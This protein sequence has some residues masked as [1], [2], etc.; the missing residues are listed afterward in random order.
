M[1]RSLILRA[2]LISL[3]IAGPLLAQEFRATING[4]ISDTSDAAVPGATVLVK[5]VET[6]QVTSTTTD[7]RGNYTASFLRPGEYTVTVEAAGF[8]KVTRS[9]LVLNVGQTA[10][11][12]IALQVSAVV[13]EV[14]VTGAT[15]LLEVS[16]ADRGGVIDPQRVAELPLLFRNP[17]FL[18]QVVPGVTYTGTPIWQRP[19]DNGAMADWGVS[20]SRRRWGEFLLDGSPN[21]AQAGGNNI[22]YVPPVD[23]VQ[24]FKIHLNSYDAQYGKT[25][26]PIMNVTLKSGGN[27]FHGTIYEFLRRTGLDANTFQ[28]NAQ[29]RPR[30]PNLQDQYGFQAQGPVYFPKL[31]NGKDKLFFMTNYERYRDQA[32]FPLTVSVPAPEF[33]NGDF[34]KLVDAQGRQI[35]IYDPATGRQ[36]GSQWVRDPFKGNLIPQNRI[37]SVAAKILSYSPAPNLTTKGVGYT[38]SNYTPPG[39]DTKDDFYNLVFKFDLN[40]GDKHRVFFHDVS[41]QRTEDS[42]ETG[43]IKE[44]PGA[45]GN[46]NAM[47]INDN[48]TGD[49]VATLQPTLIFN[50]RLSFSRYCYYGEHRDN[51]SFDLAQLGLPASTISQ[52]YFPKFFGYYQFSGYSQMGKQPWGEW[53]N[54]GAVHPTATKIV[55]PHTLKF[56]VDNRFIQFVQHNYGTPLGFTA[57]PV[58]TQQRYD[59][60]DALSGNSIAS[61]LLGNPSAGQADIYTHPTFMYRYHAPYI[62]D[63]WKLTRR[64]ALN[65][66]FR[67]DFNLPP[68]ER[69]NRM[70]RGFDPTAVNPVDKLVNRTAFPGTPTILG[71]LLFAGVGG[72]PDRPANTYRRAVQPRIGVA[73]QIRP[74]I[75]FR[76]GWGRYYVNPTNDYLQIYGYTAS[77]PFVA[78]GDSNRTPLN[79]LSNPFPTGVMKPV[80][81]SLGLATYLGNTFNSV[82]PDF[83][84]AH[85]DQFSAGFQVGLTPTQMVE[86]TYVGNRS[87]DLQSTRPYNEP[88][89]A[90]RQQCNFYEG[91]NS[92]YCNA[93]VPNPF[94]GLAPFSGTA[95]FSSPTMSRYDLARPFP[96]FGA[97]TEVMR[98]D[99]RVWYNSLQTT[100]RAKFHGLNLIAGYVLAKQIEQLGWLDVQK[101]ILQRSPYEADVP[102]R[103]TLS[104][105]WELP[106]GKGKRLLNT[107]H[108][109]W[110]RLLS[111]WETS[112]FVQWTSGRPWTLPAG[113]R[114]VNDARLKDIDWSAPVVRGV[115]PCVA[116]QNENGTFT[117]QAFSTS[118]GCGTDIST[119]NFIIQPTYAPT[120][121]PARSG[122]IRVHSVANLDMSINK[123]TRITEKVSIQFRTEV[124][125]ATN[126]NQFPRA[127]WANSPSSAEFGTIVRSTIDASNGRPRNIEFGVKLIW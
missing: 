123:R 55:G 70:N 6:N 89:L 16:K 61:F 64:L 77:T 19:F 67:W 31:Y 49:W 17:I 113:V 51:M 8:A 37:N 42:H 39:N 12:D 71:G 41:N 28:N 47:R 76:G 119:Y 121:T 108:P 21:N 2:G 57:T 66:G 60:A 96:E 59:Q 124:S 36:E 43:A 9:G 45:T 56:G 95:L 103:L 101:N 74:R 97:V 14:T 88:N 93:Q 82:N 25:D 85:V 63:D 109:F 38:Q 29:G 7:A 122:N 107:S 79:T 10:T 125:N 117:P 23:S 102:N 11:V 44:G 35:V 98:D 5:N 24:E 104:N 22:A 83:R 114:Y 40:L 90:F 52:L 69:F 65:L 81:N 62:Q 48:I 72:Q 106:I 110:S 58:F 105:L 80:G 126:T 78:S 120:A 53:T 92:A 26:G 32:P 20:G 73:Y 94:Q 13:Q 15:P 33:L 50:L 87:Y 118:Y 68:T 84:L 115:R 46:R 3:L 27:Q 91:G 1:R 18:A 116:R 111:G 75:V 99:G 127:N 112:Q 30:T 4:R 34:S 86:V 100:Y 54:T